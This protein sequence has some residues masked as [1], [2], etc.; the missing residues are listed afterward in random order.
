LRPWKASSRASCERF[1]S[2]VE[3]ASSSFSGIGSPCGFLKV[4]TPTIGTGER[5]VFGSAVE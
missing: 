2:S 3:R 5:D 1:S 4:F